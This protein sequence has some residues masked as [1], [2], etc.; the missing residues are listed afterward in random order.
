MQIAHIE[1]D[2]ARITQSK[3]TLAQAMTLL[4]N[5]APDEVAGMLLR[6]GLTNES[7]TQLQ[8]IVSDHCLLDALKHTTSNDWNPLARLAAQH[9]L[10]TS[11]NDALRWV[12]KISDAS[13]RAQ[14]LTAIAFSQT[15]TPPEESEFI[16]RGDK[17]GSAAIQA[18][19]QAGDYGA[20][21][22]FDDELD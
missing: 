5:I 9:A 13:L 1:S 6:N 8:A 2:A 15:R 3:S 10:K 12:L 11:V 22:N 21:Y 17:Q 4:K 16:M 18:R 19:L 14:C 20:S 7:T